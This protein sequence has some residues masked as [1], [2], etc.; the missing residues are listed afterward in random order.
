M[1]SLE[2]LRDLYRFTA[3]ADAKIWETVPDASGPA[4]DDR[5]RML[6]L[7]IHTVQRAF[8]HVWRNEPVIFRDA[9]EFATMA[10]LRAWA[11]PYYAEAHAFLSQLDAARLGD[12]LSLPWVRHFEQRLGRGLTTPTLGDTIFQVFSHSTHHRAQVSTRLRE[13]GIEPPLTDYI[14]WV[15][16]G[17]PDAELT[18]TAQAV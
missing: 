3:W 9:S 16:F 13:L 5:L 15:W 18:G 11:L 17:K 10:D 8:L 2:A 1:F 14:G 4:P 12:P 6:L 7:H